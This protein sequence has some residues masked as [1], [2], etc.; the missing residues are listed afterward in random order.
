[1]IFK[2]LEPFK[3]GAF[4]DYRLCKRANLFTNALINSGSSVINRSFSFLK[5]KIA[6]Y[7][8]LGNKKV[9]KEC[10]IESMTS[11]CAASIDCEDYKEHILV[12]QDTSE[13]AFGEHEARIKKKTANPGQV[14]NDAPGFMLHLSIAL[15]AQSQQI[16]GIPYATVYNWAA[17]RER[18]GSE[19]KYK[20]KP[21][22]ERESYRWIETTKQS[23]E[24]ISPNNPV[25]V[26]CDRE[27]DIYEL[28]SMQLPDHANLLIRSSQERRT[29]DNG[30]KLFE[31]MG[32]APILGYYTYT[33]PSRGH[34]H[35]ERE[36][37]IALRVE[38][39]T[40]PRPYRGKGAVK[41]IHTTDKVQLYCVFAQEIS[42]PPDGE[43]SI[44]WRLLTTH[45]VTTAEM[46]KQI[47]EW[48]CQRWII[49]EVFRVMKIKGFNVEEAQ[50]EKI[51]SL[52]KLALITAIAATKIVSLK[53]AF[54]LQ[55]E[56]VSALRNFTE[57]EV[58][59]LTNN[60]LPK[61]E[62]KTQKQKNPYKECSLIWAAWIIARLGGW[63]G[64]FSQSKPGYI[65]FKRGM[66]RYND[67]IEFID[68]KDVYK[69]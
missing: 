61:L 24:L 22:E 1:M 36:V 5:N 46:A 9:T 69:G 53:L 42:T 56:N 47:V 68:Q 11:H 49:E 25:T 59:A 28:L 57:K 32:T 43:E 51:E 23:I 21:L 4:G 17:D 40:F 27:G 58:S 60:F 54:D 37:E 35:K 62:G 38:K 48:Y 13:F 10:I 63:T 65:T 2:Q 12:I 29:A 31:I 52:E 15:G 66:D 30:R 41:N 45:T 3:K 26:I 64:Y 34:G 55:D 33:L 8:F 44:E 16:Y 50:L 6:S 19:S 14:N 67:I 18:N 20:S 39:V 7:R